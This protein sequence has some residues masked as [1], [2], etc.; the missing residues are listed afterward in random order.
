MSSWIHRLK[1]RVSQFATADLTAESTGPVVISRS[2]HTIS[3]ANISE[4]A[5]KVLYRLKNAGYQAHLVGGVIP[6]LDRKSVV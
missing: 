2:E 3:R 1:K 5:V 6:G 4:N